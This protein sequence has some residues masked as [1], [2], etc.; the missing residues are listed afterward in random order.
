MNR[1]SKYE[2]IVKI[3]QK[4]M[5]WVSPDENLLKR[6]SLSDQHKSVYMLNCTIQHNI[7]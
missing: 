4:R 1:K 7:T 3:N 5:E 2:I 6:E